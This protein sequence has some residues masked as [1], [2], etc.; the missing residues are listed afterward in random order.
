[1]REPDIYALV[2]DCVKN[3][4][5]QVTFM[6]PVMENNAY[7]CVMISIYQERR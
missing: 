4:I 2:I 6:P 1:M 5:A 3:W 7:I